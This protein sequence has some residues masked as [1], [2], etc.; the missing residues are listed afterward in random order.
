[1]AEERQH[2]ILSASSALQWVHCPPSAMLC[3]QFPDSPSEAAQEGTLAH[4]ICEL[5]LRKLFVEP[6]M[7]D[8][9]FKSSHN[10]IKKE[11]LYK[12]EMER[13]TDEYVDYVKTIVYGYETTPYIAIEKRLDYSHIAPDG[14]GTGDGVILAGSDL[15]VIDF[16]YGQ[17][18][19][20]SAEG[21]FQLSL[22]AL[23]ALKAYG[24]IYHIERVFLHIVQPRR[25]NFSKWET[26]PR[27]LVDWSI[28]VVAPAAQL[29][30]RGEGDFKQ[31]Y[32]CDKCFCDAAGTCKARAD[33]NMAVIQNHRD[34]V[35]GG[36]LNPALL[37][38]E[39]LAKLLPALELI[40]PWAKKAKAAA[41]TRALDGEE[42]PGWKPVE[43][44][45]KR[46][47]TDVTA[48]YKALVAAG[49][50]KAML[51]N[52]V[53]ISLTDVESL[54]T[55]DDKEAILAKYITKPKGK[56]TLA[57]ENDKRPV[58]VRGTTAEE[59]FGGDNT[60]KEDLQ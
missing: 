15:H 45:S 33:E 36:M 39:A 43:G 7:S 31:G 17:G 16:K 52:S 58:F 14:F 2:A 44:N 6:G 56:P 55:K 3:E 19:G 27:Y 18:I 10:K 8:R 48:A 46:V 12:P 11:P 57:R 9:T 60:F 42:I 40:E 34:P 1:M 28:A 5:K 32:W 59:D 25:N 21:N 53:P 26:Y 35:T 38:N 29:A 47:I 13:Y 37:T 20:V 50:K 24:M 49:Y 54:I 23:G 30:I 22:Y 51:Y 41:L 4:S